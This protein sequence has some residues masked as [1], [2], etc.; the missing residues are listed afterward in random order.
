VRKAIMFLA[1]VVLLAGASAAFADSG[2]INYTVN[3]TIMSANQPFT[4]T[5]SEP[6]TLN[7]LATFVPVTFISGGSSRLFS[8]GEVEFFGSGDMGLFDVDFSFGGNDFTFSFVGD[9][10]FKGDGPFALRSGNF[11]VLLGALFEN[12]NV[13]SLLVGGN[14]KAVVITP[15]PA[16]LALLSLGLAGLGVLR[17]KRLA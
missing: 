5:F 2:S 9:Q 8:G 4:F 3:S 12:D 11:P 13:E 17:K 7:A 14:V 1:V 10:I 16:S 6:A 15:E